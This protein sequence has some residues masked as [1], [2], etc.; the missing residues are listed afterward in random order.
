MERY[1]LCVSRNTAMNRIVDARSSSSSFPAFKRYLIGV[2]LPAAASALRYSSFAYGTPSET[3]H[4]F[5]RSYRTGKL[6][7]A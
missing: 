6:R 2:E 7:K 3:S 1:A 4:Y 5:S